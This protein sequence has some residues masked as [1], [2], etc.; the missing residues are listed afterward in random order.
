MEA[1]NF[2]G[3]DVQDTRKNK[4]KSGDWFHLTTTRCRC[5][6][7]KVNNSVKVRWTSY[8][9]K[10]PGNASVVLMRQLYSPHVWIL[11][12]WSV[13]PFYGRKFST[14]RSWEGLLSLLHSHLRLIASLLFVFA[15]VLRTKTR[16]VGLGHRL[17]QPMANFR[18]LWGILFLYPK[19]KVEGWTYWFNLFKMRK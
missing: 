16:K 5:R 13:F 9:N 3:H 11:N 4:I 7:E 17:L 12:S 1:D 18:S 2:L 14:H 19:P 15:Q 10:R 6:A 8:S